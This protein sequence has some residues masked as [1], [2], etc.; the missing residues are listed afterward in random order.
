MI[1][2]LERKGVL[3]RGEVRTGMGD[4]SGPAGDWGGAH[5]NPPVRQIGPGAGYL[6]P[7]T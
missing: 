1:N 7:S 5:A 6:F 4:P 3:T 2:G